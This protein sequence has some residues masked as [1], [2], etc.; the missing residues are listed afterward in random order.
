MTVDPWTLSPS[1]SPGGTLE[2]RSASP[3]SR[4]GLEV[5][6][7][8][9]GRCQHPEKGT[10][11]LTVGG[12]VSGALGGPPQTA[13]TSTSAPFLPHRLAL[14]KEASF[15]LPRV[16]SSIHTPSGQLETT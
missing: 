1:P 12:G 8:S 10:S 15:S 16:I 2:G 4:A 5:T 13:P 9:P 3:D 7:G 11:C 14:G 6:A